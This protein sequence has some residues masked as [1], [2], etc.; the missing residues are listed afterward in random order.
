MKKKICIDCGKEKP[1]SVFHMF[2]NS[3]CRFNT[4]KACVRK[5]VEKRQSEK[6]QK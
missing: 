4:C 3:G 6:E 1:I 5:A 2:Y